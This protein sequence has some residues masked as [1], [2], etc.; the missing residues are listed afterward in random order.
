MTALRPQDQLRKQQCV[1]LPLAATQIRIL[2]AR[3]RAA[4]GSVGEL[5][6]TSN[7][8]FSGYLNMP[9]AMAKAMRGEWFSAGDL[10][11]LDDEGYL[12][13]VDRKNDMIISGGENVY[14]REVEEVLL[15]HP[16]IEQAAVIGLPHE[17]WG[18]QVVAF[19]VVRPGMNVSER[20]TEAGL[21]GEAFALQGAEGV[22]YGD[23]LPRNR[24][25]KIDRREL[26]EDAAKA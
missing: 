17:H 2:D 26:R 11:R 15:A 5:Y 13:L 14:P 19:V 25:G 1:G 16:A 8:M 21:R 24:M 10:G 6:S 12:Y 22:P 23:D 9:D 3:R 7:Y 4:P 18:E 20:R